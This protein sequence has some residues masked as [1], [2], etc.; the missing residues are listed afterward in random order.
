M[1]RYKIAIEESVL[2]FIKKN[3]NRKLKEEFKKCISKIAENPHRSK[4]LRYRL[5]GF[6]RAR[7]DKF[8]II[9]EIEE[10]TIIINSI[11]HRKKSYRKI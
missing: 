7:F 2:R 9:F 8:R 3:F 4:P 10:D 5:K 6:Y 11:E 1:S